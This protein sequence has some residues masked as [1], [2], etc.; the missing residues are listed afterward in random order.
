MHFIPSALM[1]AFHDEMY[2]RLG[3][4]WLKRK[5]KKEDV[6][7]RSI[8]VERG[9]LVEVEQAISYG[10]N[11][12]THIIRTPNDAYTLLQLACWNDH[13]DAVQ[14]LLGTGGVD[15]HLGSETRKWTPLYIAARNGHFESAQLLVEHGVDL[16]QPTTGGITA[17]FTASARGHVEVVT[18][19]V[20]AGA[21]N[22]KG[23][24]GAA[25]GGGIMTNMNNRVMRRLAGIR[26]TRVDMQSMGA[27]IFPPP[28][29]IAGGGA[30]APVYDE[31]EE[32]DDDDEE[33]EQLDVWTPPPPPAAY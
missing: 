28:D 29:S 18:L 5:I 13:Y 7:D 33:V 12:N 30:L 27:N 11:L 32:E 6:S 24:I 26:S 1:L 8:E 25:V 16:D 9:N 15:P 31:E 2:G 10:V 14:R 3:R 4:S 20:D 17:L 19:L 21:K 22:E 23:W